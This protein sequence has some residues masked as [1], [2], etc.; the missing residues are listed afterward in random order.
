MNTF[1]VNQ[2][3]WPTYF[4]DGCPPDGAVPAD[5]VVFRLVGQV[6]PTLMDFRP[7]RIE[8]P[9]RDLEHCLCIACG[10]SV[11]R[12]IEDTERLR[13]RVPAF[14]NKRIARGVLAHSLGVMRHTPSSGGGPS[15]HTWW[16]PDG[17]DPSDRFVVQT[18][19]AA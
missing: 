18:G 16:L 14:R 2:S 19:S 6:P 3:I 10:L 15:H 4:P 12:K 9:H 17:V 5:G 13:R 7:V 8:Q 1:P 11:N